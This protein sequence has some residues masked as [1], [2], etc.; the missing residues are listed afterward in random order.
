M[1]ELR[2]PAMSGPTAASM[3]QEIES[4]SD[5]ELCRCVEQATNVGGI[6]GVGTMTDFELQQLVDWLG[7][8]I[9]VEEGWL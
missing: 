4:M 9:A 1:L 6:P 7:R 8:L 2:G 3:L 5:D